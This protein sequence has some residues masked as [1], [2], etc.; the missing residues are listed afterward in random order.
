V[1]EALTSQEQAIVDELLGVQG[2]SVEIGGYYH[3]DEQKTF[4]VMRP[5]A[6]LNSVID[7]LRK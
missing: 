6:T 4:A 2:H 7:S 3:P 5:S 1:A